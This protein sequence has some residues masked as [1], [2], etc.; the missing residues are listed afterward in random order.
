MLSVGKQLFKIAFEHDPAAVAAG[1]F[2][3][4]DDLVGG[5]HYLFVMLHHNYG[6][7]DALKPAENAYQFLGVALVKPDARLVK[8][9]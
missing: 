4:V 5:E 2:A 1:V 7:A 3:Y 6:V 8:D 9:V